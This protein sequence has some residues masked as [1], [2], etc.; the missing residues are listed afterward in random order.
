M[1]AA[2]KREIE[3]DRGKKKSRRREQMGEED[4]DRG[5]ERLK[6]ESSYKWQSLPE[7][8]T[9]VCQHCQA[10][11]FP[12]CYHVSLPPLGDL[13]TVLS[14]ATSKTTSGSTTVPSPLLLIYP[15]G[16]LATLYTKCHSVACTC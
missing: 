2:K 7:A 9:R 10:W 6:R 5:R 12:N 1:S 4:R 15:W 11:R 3:R 16:L 13:F 14:R 8:M